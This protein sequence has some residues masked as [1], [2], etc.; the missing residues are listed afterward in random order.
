MLKKEKKSV[1]HFPVNHFRQDL[2]KWY[3]IH[4][5]SLP[6]RE[7]KNPYLIWISEIM[8]QQTQVKTVYPYYLRFIDQFSTVGEL[9]DAPIALVLKYWEGLGYYHRAIKLHQT[10]R[11][12]KDKFQG[13][14]P[15]KYEDLLD[16]PGI[17]HYTAGAIASFAYNQP[18]PA[19]DGNV[20]R[21]IS[22]F[23]LITE[24]IQSRAT[25]HQIRNYVLMLISR[26]RAGIFN[27]AIMELGAT[28]CKPRQP[29]CLKC[30]IR[31]N[32]KAFKQGK[33]NEIPI[34]TKKVAPKKVIM[35][36]AMIS[37][38][39]KL[40][41]VK[42]SSRGLLPN[43]WSLPSKEK[44][45]G[46][47]GGLSIREFLEKFYQIKID[48]TPVF[49][50]ETKHVFTHRIWLMKL[51]Q[52]TSFPE[53]VLDSKKQKWIPIPHL[54][55]YAIPIAYQKLLRYLGGVKVK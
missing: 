16:L 27:Q 4:Y 37:R 22:R 46:F 38:E 20:S 3:N 51:Y 28:V 14:F 31:S 39:N 24:N 15:E 5:R 55:H 7:T 18:E 52:F 34:K 40:L 11:I 29:S 25:Q 9:A 43:M 35:E 8:L 45:K 41:L 17:G 19:I 49:L 44:M 26:I 10:A 1:L 53:I 12:I 23:F 30:P 33:Q 6:W 2:I 47:A 13:K 48:E 42:Q 36:I 21:V 32:C 54:N 50:A